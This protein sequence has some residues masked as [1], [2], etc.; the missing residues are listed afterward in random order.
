MKKK[1]IEMSKNNRNRKLN[2][3]NTKNPTFI[4]SFIS[5]N[6]TELANDQFNNNYNEIGINL[7]ESRQ[8][9]EKNNQQLIQNYLNPFKTSYITQNLN[10]SIRISQSSQKL[11]KD[12]KQEQQ[13]SFETTNHFT[14]K[15]ET[16]KAEIER[17]KAENK[18][19]TSR[20][21][22]LEKVNKENSEEIFFL[23][24][25]INDLEKQK[26]AATNVVISPT[27]NKEKRVSP[28]FLSIMFANPGS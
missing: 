11:I 6:E 2:K 17:L 10:N 16:L 5:H 24:E 14:K 28:P 4:S 25:K 8:E 9:E 19:K 20:I 23:K 13:E 15:L 27:I 12:V 7:N 22:E 21:F 18:T 26:N 3:F 1:N